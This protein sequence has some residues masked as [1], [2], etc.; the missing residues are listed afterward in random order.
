MK[1]NVRCAYAQK[2]II[3][4]KENKIVLRNDFYQKLKKFIY[5]NNSVN[6]EVEEGIKK[7]ATYN[8]MKGF[9]RGRYYK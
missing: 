9:Q 1:F 7:N 6:R 4:F 2:L 8:N 5:S 3:T